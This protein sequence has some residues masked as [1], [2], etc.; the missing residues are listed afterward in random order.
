MWSHGNERFNQKMDQTEHAWEV[1]GQR[2][3]GIIVP[4]TMIIDYARLP[5]GRALTAR[6]CILMDSA[7]TAHALEQYQ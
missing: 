7:D 2:N 6:C 5:T 1:K 4:M 3:I